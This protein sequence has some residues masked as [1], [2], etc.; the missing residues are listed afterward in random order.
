MKNNLLLACLVCALVGGV[1]AGPAA[2]QGRG[3]RLQTWQRQ[4]EAEAA[5]Q[6]RGAALALAGGPGG[7]L[8]TPLG[9]LR[10]RD[11]G[12]RLAA[13]KSVQAVVSGVAPMTL[14][15]PAE[16]GLVLVPGGGGYGPSW[17][18]KEYQ[19]RVGEHARE[20]R[21]RLE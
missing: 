14:Y 15:G 18:G 3:E 4:A 1:S 11:A 17:G 10:D 16:R 9:L 6:R 20:L 5:E 21:A 12:V 19:R 8:P 7:S 13:V 2:G